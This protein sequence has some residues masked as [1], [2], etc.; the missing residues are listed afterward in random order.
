MTALDW[1]TNQAGFSAS[2]GFSW[3]IRQ[4]QPRRPVLLE[5]RQ[6][7]Q[8]LFTLEHHLSLPKV[9]IPTSFAMT[10]N[11]ESFRLYLMQGAPFLIGE[12]R[13]GT[14]PGIIHM[15][16]ISKWREYKISA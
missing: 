11:G 13:Y 9:L 6:D 16:E 7:G 8:L 12:A 15:N 10:F 3:S 4:E 2:A 5:I 14:Q 1:L